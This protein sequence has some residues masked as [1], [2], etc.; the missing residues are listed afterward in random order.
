[1]QKK[2]ETMEAPPKK[3]ILWKDGVP[4]PLAQ[5]YRW[6]GEDGLW[7]KCMGLKRGAIGNTLGENIE[8]LMGTHWEKK[9]KNPLPPPTQNLKG[10]KSR[11]F[12]CILSL[13]IGCTKF[14]FPTWAN[15]PI[16]NWGYLLAFTNSTLPSTICTRDKTIH[17]PIDPLTRIFLIINF[18]RSVGW[19]SST[20]RLSQIWLLE[21]VV[22]IW[23]FHWLS[24]QNI[25]TL[26]HYY[27]Q[28]KEKKLFVTIFLF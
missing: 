28:Q 25:A 26:G 10:K 27:Q 14:L 6:E 17:W 21:V 11:H 22:Q 1:M 16:I 3:K 12:E 7:A 18:V 20:R 2:V 19:S 9:E 4:C 24:P 23:R 8:N 5:P 15:T 13:P